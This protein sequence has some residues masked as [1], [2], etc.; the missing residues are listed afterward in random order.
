MKHPARARRGQSG[1]AD[2][3]R[4]LAFLGRATRRLNRLSE[5]GD[6]GCHGWP[7]QNWPPFLLPLCAYPHPQHAPTPFIF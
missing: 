5:Q 3:A 6:V 2:R 4:E 7:I 1:M